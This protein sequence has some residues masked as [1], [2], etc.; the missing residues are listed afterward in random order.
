[1]YFRAKETKNKQ[2][3]FSPVFQQT[4]RFADNIKRPASR[5]PLFSS[6]IILLRCKGVQLHPS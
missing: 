5:G 4:L 2:T 1:M 3:G 6:W